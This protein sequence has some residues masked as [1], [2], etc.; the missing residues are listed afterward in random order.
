MI[1]CLNNWVDLND[2]AAAVEIGR[3]EVKTKTTVTATR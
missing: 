2:I 1:V 3:T